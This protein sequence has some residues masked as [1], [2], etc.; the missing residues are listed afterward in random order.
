MTIF[1]VLTNW[2]S[3]LFGIDVARFTFPHRFETPVSSWISQ[4][5]ATGASV[6]CPGST[7]RNNFGAAFIIWHVLVPMN[8]NAGALHNTGSI[9]HILHSRKLN[10]PIVVPF[11]ALALSFVDEG[12]EIFVTSVRVCT[13]YVFIHILSNFPL[14]RIRQVLSHPFWNVSVRSLHIDK[15][16]I[17]TA[18]V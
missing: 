13:A 8:I 7:Q 11:K 9:P 4:R 6:A 17:H 3:G 14:D 5:N 1:F 15:I 10:E 16:R 18:A 2:I 12:V